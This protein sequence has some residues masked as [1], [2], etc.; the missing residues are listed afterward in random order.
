MNFAIWGHI[1]ISE[2]ETEYCFNKDLERIVFMA[3]GAM[4]IMRFFY[5]NFQILFQ[6]ADIGLLLANIVPEVCLFII[7]HRESAQLAQENIK[8]SPRRRPEFAGYRRSSGLSFLFRKG[9]WR[10]SMGSVHRTTICV[11]AMTLFDENTVHY[12]FISIV[13]CS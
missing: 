5:V 9:F 3:L 12:L 4:D 13:D 2:I 1:R 7:L 8:S 10:R 6:T 11:V